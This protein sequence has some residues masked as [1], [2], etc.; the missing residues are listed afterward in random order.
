MVKLMRFKIFPLGSISYCTSTSLRTACLPYL[1][2][3]VCN[4][5]EGDRVVWRSSAGVIHCVFDQI[6]NIQNYY[7]TPNENLGW[8]GASD[9]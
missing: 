2:C 7:T 6:P 9:R 4:R 5:G 1:Y 3:T 8:E